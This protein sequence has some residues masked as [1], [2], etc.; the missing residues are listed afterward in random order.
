V[1]R[2]YYDDYSNCQAQ[3]SLNNYLLR[4]NI[5][6][7]AGVD[8]RALT[9]RLRNKGTMRA[10]LTRWNGS[11]DMESLVSRAR[12]VVALS[13]KDLVL[14]TSSRKPVELPPLADS[15]ALGRSRIVLIDFGVKSNI[16]NSLR[17]RGVSVCVVPH[18]TSFADILALDPH[19]VVLSNGP[20]DPATMPS[21]VGVAR[22][23]VAARIPLL[24]ICLGHQILGQAIGATTSRLKFG[25]HGGNH[26]VKDLTTG[27]VHITA[28]N[29]EFQVDAAAVPP[30][31]GFYV[32]HLNLND[33]SVEGLAH[34]EWPVFSVQY[35][36]EGA[37]GPQDNQYIFDR[38][39]KLVCN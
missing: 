17:R 14:D 16:A 33:G 5:P 2:E 25:H 19:G 1:V 11:E 38:F 37:P 31:S 26:P 10:I 35:H 32:S 34:R 36:P 12:G 6:A 7:L 29:H 24:G 30:H 39:L 15:A 23:L 18:T 4:R 13:D 3:D 20:G 21:A 8:T 27:R 28:Q 9:R 22:E